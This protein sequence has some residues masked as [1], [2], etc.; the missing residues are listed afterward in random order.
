M[1]IERK[2]RDPT[3]SLGIPCSGDLPRNIILGYGYPVK[4]SLFTWRE[5]APTQKKL[6]KITERRRLTVRVESR[7]ATGNLIMGLDH[8]AKGERYLK[9]R[10]EEYAPI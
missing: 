6:L 4:G 9:R 3:G 5:A 7:V 1:N 2:K 10:R 8:N